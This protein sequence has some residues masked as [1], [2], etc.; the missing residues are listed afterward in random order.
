MFPYGYLLIRL[1]KGLHFTAQVFRKDGLAADGYDPA[2]YRAGGGGL[3]GQ[4]C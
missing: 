1:A 2:H 4:D 3:A